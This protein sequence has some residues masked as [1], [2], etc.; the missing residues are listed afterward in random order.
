ME[1]ETIG[2]YFLETGLQVMARALAKRFDALHLSKWKLSFVK[3]FVFEFTDRVHPTTGGRVFMLLEPYVDGRLLHLT[4]EGSGYKFKHSPRDIKDRYSIAPAFSHFTAHITGG[5]LVVTDLQ[6]FERDEELVF[7]DPRIGANTYNLFGGG[8][9]CRK[10]H[11]VSAFF[12][13]HVC[14]DF[15]RRLMLPG[16]HDLGVVG[17]KPFETL[18]Q[19]IIDR[20]LESTANAPRDLV[21]KK[22]LTE[23]SAEYLQGATQK[24]RY[25]F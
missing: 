17:K 19:R 12:E 7:T 16:L 6:A 9:R 14:N 13:N 22:A 2:Q 5:S 10:H 23:F 3:S 25:C 18:D 8:A 24:P 20:I 4:G 15:C 11:S 1:D 21:S